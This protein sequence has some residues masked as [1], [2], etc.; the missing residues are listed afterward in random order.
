VPA[1]SSENLYRLFGVTMASDY[2]FANPLP[3]VSGTPDVMFTCMRTSPFAT[4]VVKRL[5]YAGESRT[6]DGEIWFSIHAMGDGYIVHYAKMVDF[7][8]SS[9]TIIA[10]LLDPAYGYTIEILL[11]GE[12]LSL[13]LELRGIPMIHASAAVVDE[14]A[15]AF[16]SSSKG[17]KSCLAA[18]FAQQGHQILTD[19]ILPLEDRHDRFLAR[20]GFPALRMWPDQAGHFFGECENLALVHPQHTKRRIPVGPEG[21]GTFCSEEKPLKVIYLPQRLGTDSDI[22]IDPLSK[23]NAFFA[24]IQNSFAA[25]LVELLGLQPQRMKFFSRMVQ[26]VPVRRLNYPEGFNHLSRVVDAVLE[27]SKSL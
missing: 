15:I 17:G 4:E 26:Q 5:V 19:D 8:L 18:A 13:W 9:D 12:I 2:H 1:C 6:D 22:T 25:G 20:P 27:D 16:L 3:R 23:K 21:F 14:N 7:Y 10:H 11:L 24:L